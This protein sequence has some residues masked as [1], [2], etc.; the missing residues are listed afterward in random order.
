MNGCIFCKIIKG[1]IP[2]TKVYEDESFV[3]IRDINPVY[4]KHLLIITK[5]HI[6]FVNEVKLS[7]R[8]LFSTVF[9]VAKTV[10]LNEGVSESGYRLS[11]N[12]GKDAGQLV[13][14]FHMHLL[15]GE[16]LR[17]L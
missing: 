9:E 3:V 2:S 6:A 16:P 13:P 4:K 12:C 11:V 17:E 7:D 15:A 14:H 1:D 8:A 5:R 10:A